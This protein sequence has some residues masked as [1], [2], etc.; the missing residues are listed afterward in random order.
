MANVVKWLTRQIV[1]LVFEGSI[2]FNRPIENY[3]NSLRVRMIENLTFNLKVR[4]WGFIMPE[5]EIKNL[6]FPVALKQRVERYLPTKSL[7]ITYINGQLIT[8][9]N[10]N[11]NVINP[12]RILIKKGNKEIMLLCYGDFYEE[13]NAVFLYT[14]KNRI[15]WESVKKVLEFW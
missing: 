10:T 14:F 5:I 11:V 9:N 12:Y 7:D 2:P 4:K 13:E 3:S 6:G 15:A 1:A 8:F